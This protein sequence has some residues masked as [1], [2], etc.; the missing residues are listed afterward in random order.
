[1]RSGFRQ[2]SGTLCRSVSGSRQGREKG[3]STRPAE[4]TV[5]RPVGAAG[6]SRGDK[7]PC[8]PT[9]TRS[10]F[11]L[12]S[13]NI[14]SLTPPSLQVTQILDLNSFLCQT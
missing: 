9:Y 2:P 1:M 12:P 14:P 8:T 11:L 5:A 13:V 6:S 4:W 3:C 7:G 10:R